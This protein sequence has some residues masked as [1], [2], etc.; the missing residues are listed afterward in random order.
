MSN[1]HIKKD[2]Y[3]ID[4][5]KRK[6]GKNSDYYLMLAIEDA[7]ITNLKMTPKQLKEFANQLLICA[8][9]IEDAQDPLGQYVFFSHYSEALR[10]SLFNKHKLWD[11]D[12][13]LNGLPHPYK[14]DN[15]AYMTDLEYQILNYVIQNVKDVEWTFNKIYDK[16]DFGT[17]NGTYETLKTVTMY[18]KETL[19]EITKFYNKEIE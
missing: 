1:I 2:N 5:D 13:I 12:E 3:I 9:K 16:S 17:L 14:C 19:K 7:Q 8:E 4:Y 10:F 11:S 18:D 6:S 15:F